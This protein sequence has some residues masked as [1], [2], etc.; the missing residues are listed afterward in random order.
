[1]PVT[2]WTAVNNNGFAQST[3]S[4]VLSRQEG[5]S[6]WESTDHHAQLCTTLSKTV[7]SS[8]RLAKPINPLCV[9]PQTPFSEA[10]GKFTL[11]QGRHLRALFCV[12]RPSFWLSAHIRQLG[13]RVQTHRLDEG[14]HIGYQRCFKLSLKLCRLG[15]GCLSQ[16][17]RG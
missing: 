4:W 15:P 13:S 1:M 2:R 6:S 11:P 12:G 17:L 14:K 10:S 16:A 7:L 3:I 8:A 5:R 9:Q